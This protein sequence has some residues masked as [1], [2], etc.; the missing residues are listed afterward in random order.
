MSEEQITLAEGLT[1]DLARGCLLREGAPVHLRPQ[2]YEVLKYLAGNRGRLVGK[3]RL[4]EEV[5]KGRAVTDGA[6][7]KCIE[8]VREALGERARDYVRTVRGRGYILDA[9]GG[10]EVVEAG[11]LR[12]EQVDLVRILVEDE[13]ETDDEPGAGAVRRAL[14]PSDEGGRGGFGRR[15]VA[16]AVSGLL[17]LTLGAGLAYYFS[18]RGAARGEAGAGV[19]SL[20]VLPFKPLL[21]E[22]R[23]EALELGLA[24]TLITRLSGVGDTTVRPVSAVRGYSGLAQDPVAAGH[25]L[26]VDA[27]LDGSILRAGDRVR[28][29]V[30]LI[31]VADGRQL[32]AGRF[33]ERFGDIFAVL[34]SITERVAAEMSRSLSGRD[35]AT[36]AKRQTEN[37]EAYQRYLKGRYFWNRRT[38]EG[39]VKAVEYFKEAVA[40]DPDY[41][42]AHAGL[43]DAYHFLAAH[44][45][46]ARADRY[47]GARSAA[48]RA[49]ELD[50]GLAE[51]HASLGLLAMNYDWDW[52]AAER[53]FKRAIELNPHYATAHH[54]Y[55]EYLNT[56]GRHD[57]SLRE[58]ERAAE[59]D[60]LSLIINTDSGKCLYM[61]RRYDEAV[62]QLRRTLELDPS[63]FMA[64]IWLGL[65]YEG[66]G[67]HGEALAE[68]EKAKALSEDMMWAQGYTAYVYGV[69][70]RRSEARKL[71]HELLAP[72]RQDQIDPTAV[73]SAYI[74]LG[75]KDQAFAWLEKEYQTRS[76]GLTSLKVF[77]V[78]DALRDDPRF[79]DM[80]RRVGLAP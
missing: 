37:V 8:E 68:F 72:S 40:L 62:E 69:Q 58:I 22:A 21:P 16:L 38:N 10:P 67:L 9:A 41:A 33:D 30:R 3:D 14:P 4:I 2:A 63:Y 1:L 55:A 65:A 34:D 17:F 23:D 74:G 45:M 49:L 11:P 48:V 31:R 51:A 39:Y 27:V 35:R 26:Q 70:G 73:V 53:E 24:D 61:A 43:A 47:A 76:V 20:A 46:A 19:R 7:G 56:Q 50:E 25:A 32:W 80:M 79:A 36:L 6:L 42:Q 13:F 5:W 52:P 12:T 75:E 71:V 77:P 54:W 59:L 28:V 78:Y 60:P 18:G 64:R 66:K 57:E 29:T 44:D 15:A